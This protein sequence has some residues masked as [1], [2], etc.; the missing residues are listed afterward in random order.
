[1]DNCFKMLQVKRVDLL[2][3]TESV[4]WTTAERIFG[5]RAEFKMLPTSFKQ[6]S[7]SLMV[8]KSY[9]NSEALVAEFNQSLAKVA[10]RGDI[11]KLLAEELK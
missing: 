9:P 5:S 1:L 4:G 10:K 11:E 8:S 2:L 3:V 6:V 7:L